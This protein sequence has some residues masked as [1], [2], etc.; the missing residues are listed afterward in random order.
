MI[1]GRIIMPEETFII[2]TDDINVEEIM[3]QIRE[4]IAKRNIGEERLPEL[5]EIRDKLNSNIQSSFDRHQLEQNIT[6][7][8][9]KWNILL[10]RPITSHRKIIGKFIVFGKRIIRKVLRWYMQSLFG[11]QIEFNSSVTRTLNEMNRYIHESEQR[12]TAY[13]NIIK[14]LMDRIDENKRNINNREKTVEP[15]LELLSLST[16]ELKSKLEEL[17]NLQAKVGII[18]EIQNNIQTLDDIQDKL[19]I[20]DKLESEIRGL[21]DIQN[22]L[23]IIDELQNELSAVDKIQDRVNIIEEIHQ[24]LGALPKL[25]KK[26]DLI[27]R[28]NIVVASRLRRI[29]RN[30]KYNNYTIKDPEIIS[31]P[32]EEIDLDYFLFEERYR[33]SREELRE[34]LIP[35]LEYFKGKQEVLDI[36]CGRGEFIELLLENGIS[37]KGVDINIDMVLYCQD[38]G[39]PVIQESALDYLNKLQDHSLGGIFLG[40]VIEHLSPNELIKLVRLAYRKLAPGACFVAETINPQCLLVFTESYFLDIS[41]TRMIHPYTIRFILESEG[42]GNVAIKYMSKVEDKLRI[43]P[44]EIENVANIEQFNATIQKLNDIIYGYRD[45]AIVGRK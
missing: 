7:N 10:D 17:E 39:L 36:G 28:E 42:F 12:M 34:R 30:L 24:K 32:T 29:E 20:V 21:G 1:E 41:H 5:S 35:Y 9:M 13:E 26:I 23:S 6:I 27:E 43:P 45:Y 19:K 44:I 40:Q 15:K 14:N 33:G 37:A 25:N 2:N 16:Q 31:S 4:N 8:N 3:R 38:R 11:Q 22:K 18:E